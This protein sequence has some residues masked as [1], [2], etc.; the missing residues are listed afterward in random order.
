MMMVLESQIS[1]HFTEFSTIFEK[2]TSNEYSDEQ[3]HEMMEFFK[4]QTKERHLD[5]INKLALGTGDDLDKIGEIA[6]SVLNKDRQA[7]YGCKD[8]FLSLLDGAISS[9]VFSP[10]RKYQDKS[11]PVSNT[12]YLDGEV[13]NY[14]RKNDK[15][16]EEIQLLRSELEERMSL[17]DNLETK[18]RNLTGIKEQFGKVLDRCSSLEVENDELKSQLCLDQNKYRKRLEEAL[19]SEEKMKIE[20]NSLEDSISVK[21]YLIKSF[22]NEKEMMI[23]DFQLLSEVVVE[24]DLIIQSLNEDSAEERDMERRE[25]LAFL[26]DTAASESTISDLSSSNTKLFRTPKKNCEDC[27]KQPNISPLLNSNLR[28]RNEYFDDSS[29]LLPSR[30]KSINEELDE[31][32]KAGSEKKCD[33]RKIQLTEL[34]GKMYLLEVELKTSRETF[35]KSSKKLLGSQNI[36]KM[37]RF[38]V[39]NGKLTKMMF[40]NYTGVR[41]N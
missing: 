2:I 41:I 33:K 40:T 4:T 27:G 9:V 19:K 14:R 32:Q 28:K 38:R 13:E 1:V 35:E 20:I 18:N 34:V 8:L 12:A 3:K 31:I 11:R 36:N 37:L 24:R 10:A 39:E 17:L 21:R 5:L 29:N 22:E 30:P 23:T 25:N 16:V 7:D 15:L 6:I 26:L